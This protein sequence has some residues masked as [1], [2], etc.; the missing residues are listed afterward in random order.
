MLI[1][2]VFQIMKGLLGDLKKKVLVLRDKYGDIIVGHVKPVDECKDEVLF[3]SM[4][5]WHQQTHVESMDWIALFEKVKKNLEFRDLK[6]IQP[7]N[8][9]LSLLR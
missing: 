8:A 7:Q 6:F 1:Y 3:Q 5:R 2:V 4:Q 9:C